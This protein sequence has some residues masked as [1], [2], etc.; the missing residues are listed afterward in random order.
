MQNTHKVSKMNSS[1]K[2]QCGCGSMAATCKCPSTCDCRS[3]SCR[4]SSSCYSPTRSK[5]MEHF[6]MSYIY[7]HYIYLIIIILIIIFLVWYIW[8]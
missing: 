8:K 6:D 2:C 3:S 1:L 4:R 5:N 7:D